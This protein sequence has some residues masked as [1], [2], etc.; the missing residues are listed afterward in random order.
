MSARIFKFGPQSDSDD[1]IIKYGK[2]L[3]WINAFDLRVRK[4]R[5][6]G[7]MAFLSN[8]FCRLVCIDKFLLS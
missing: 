6:V 4:V 3:W 7:T 5:K 8:I 1:L 2:K